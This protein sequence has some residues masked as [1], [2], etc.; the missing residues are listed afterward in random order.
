VQAR[1]SARVEWY[2]VLLI[3][4]ELMLAAY[5]LLPGR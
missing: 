2:I 1:S 4:A 3:V 5:S